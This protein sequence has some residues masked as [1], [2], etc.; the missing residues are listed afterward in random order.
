[1]FRIGRLL[2]LPALLLVSTVLLAQGTS[3]QATA[4]CNF[5][6]NH[7]VVIEYQRFSFHSKTPVFGREIPYDKVWAPGGKPMTLFT[8]V[9]VMIGGQNIPVGVTHGL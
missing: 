3:S 1:M 5:D 9:P 8:N 4:T 7:Q 6:A 2:V